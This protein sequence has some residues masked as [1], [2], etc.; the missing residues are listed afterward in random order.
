MPKTF[1]VQAFHH[2][3][4]GQIVTFEEVKSDPAWR[5]Q[6]LRSESEQLRQSIDQFANLAEALASDSESEKH[7]EH[8][9][10]L[11]TLARTLR[12]LYES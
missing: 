1:T 3:N 12:S 2:L 10:D 8:Y 9:A 7:T 5:D 11:R 6:V 4:D